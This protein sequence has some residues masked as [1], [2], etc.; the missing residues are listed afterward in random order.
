[1]GI[2]ELVSEKFF[3]CNQFETPR[4]VRTIIKEVILIR[5]KRHTKDMYIL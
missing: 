4:I 3:L 2:V 5:N 1:M